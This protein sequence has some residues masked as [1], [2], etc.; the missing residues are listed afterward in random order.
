MWDNDNH[1][2]GRKSIQKTLDIIKNMYR[3]MLMTY[4]HSSISRSNRPKSQFIQ[5]I[6]ISSESYLF[7]D[8]IV[9]APDNKPSNKGC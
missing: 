5:S 2:E 7:I 9:S 8:T 4:Y 6:Y 3:Y 1:G